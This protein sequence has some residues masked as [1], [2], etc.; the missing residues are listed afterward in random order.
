M[1]NCGITETYDELSMQIQNEHENTIVSAVQEVFVNIDKEKLKKCL[2]ESKSFYDDGYK[3]G[4]DK[5]FEDAL[6]AVLT[7]IKQN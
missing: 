5:G 7:D 3:D 2:Y 1:F 6:Y 4:Y